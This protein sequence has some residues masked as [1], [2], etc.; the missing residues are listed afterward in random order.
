MDASINNPK[1]FKNLRRFNLIM[2][3]IHFAQGIMMLVLSLTWEKLLNFKPHIFGGFL[4]YDSYFQG[5]YTI[6]D[7]LFVLPFGI[8]VS[9]FLFISA[10][11]H[12]FI[13]VPKTINNVYNKG[14]IE[15]RNSFR[16]YEYAISSSLMIILIAVLFG[17][18]D[19]FI[20]VLMFAL[21]ASMNLFGLLME[22][23]NKNKD[24]PT[25]LPF[26]FGAI[27][28]VIPWIIILIVGFSKSD[29]TQIPW[30][31]YAILVSYF[32]LFNCF[33]IN[34]ILQYM[35]IGKRK[36]YLFGER[37][38]IILSLA[39]KTLLAWFVLFGAM[40]PS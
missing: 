18:N 35:Q 37:I 17:I 8:L 3:I 1:T 14:L 25:W 26:I 30:F 12:L 11:F 33:P 7:D 5:L 21:N 15:C 10:F 24:K 38:Y 4:R 16:W 9:V 2:G 28:G 40:Q 39:A 31:V 29:P 22:K 13:S 19:I 34:M 27:V 32:I 36:N 20:L 6:K 23:M